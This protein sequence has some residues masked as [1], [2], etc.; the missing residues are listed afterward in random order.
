MPERSRSVPSAPGAVLKR[1]GTGPGAFPKRSRT[2]LRESVPGASRS[3]RERSGSAPAGNVRERPG[4]FRERPGAS[5]SAPGA[6]PGF[7]KSLKTAVSEDGRRP[8]AHLLASQAEEKNFFIEEKIFSSA[9]GS[10]LEAR[11][12]PRSLFEQIFESVAR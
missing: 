7:K 4:A 11:R 9:L 10:K 8:R 3:V 2:F 12:L 1:S 6:R 5:G